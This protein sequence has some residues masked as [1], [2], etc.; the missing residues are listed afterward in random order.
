[1]TPHRLPNYLKTHRKHSGLTQCDI[2]FLLG[3]SDGA[4]LSR[5][6]KHHRIPSLEIALAFESIFKTPVAELFAG[7]HDS[8]RSGVERRLHQ[9]A[10][11]LR[12]SGSPDGKPSRKLHWLAE[13]H[14]IEGVQADTVLCTH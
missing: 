14:G 2:A 6:E 4:Q 13:H 12:E 3:D 7:L 8:A 1:M 5:Y 11:E 10:S 9:L